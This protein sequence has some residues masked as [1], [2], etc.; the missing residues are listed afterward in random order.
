MLA[1]AANRPVIGARK[2]APNTMLAIIG[3]HV[4]AIAALMSAKMEL[5]SKFVD[6]P[7]KI[8]FIHPKTPPPPKPIQTKTKTP[9]TLTAV[10]AETT[11]PPIHFTQDPVEPVG[12]KFD[13]GIIGGGGAVVIPEFIRPVTHYPIKLGPRLATPE[14]ELKPPYPQSKL[15]SEEEAVLSLK[16]T[17]DQS[18]RVVAVDPVG[19]TDAAFLTAARRHLLAHWRYRPASEDGRAVSSSTVITLRFQ[20]DG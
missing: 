16:L 11:T 19:R 8:D 1:Y 10:K 4:A 12:P 13:T 20:L 9:T 14:A 2:P 6:P 15:L 3:I 18:G 7:I 5:P 17:I